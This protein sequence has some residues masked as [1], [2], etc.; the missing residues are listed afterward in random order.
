[1]RSLI[2]AL[3]L[4]SLFACTKNG[5]EPDPIGPPPENPEPTVPGNPNPNGGSSGGSFYIA[6]CTYVEV[7]PVT[8]YTPTIVSQMP[9]GYG[10]FADATYDKGWAQGYGDAL[11]Y[12]NYYEIA[13]PAGLCPVS[14]KRVIVDASGVP[15]Y[16]E[17][18]Y[19]TK[20]SEHPAGV[21]L[22]MGSCGINWILKKCVLWNA[23]ESK[24]LRLRYEYNK[25][26]VG[27]KTQ[28]EILFD[29]GRYDGFITGI[30]YQPYTN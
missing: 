19:I 4:I 30:S 24:G 18:D 25:N 13:Q 14:M 8:F 22:V 1:M 15:K 20:R 3:A 7:P 12:H 29:N 2:C 11:F 6:S 9:P 28:E 5:I 27:S 10:N 16:E 23:Y 17:L 21:I 26:Y